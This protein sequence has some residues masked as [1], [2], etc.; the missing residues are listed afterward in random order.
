MKEAALDKW[1]YRR[2]YVVHELSNH[3]W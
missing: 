1:N 2:A 3:S